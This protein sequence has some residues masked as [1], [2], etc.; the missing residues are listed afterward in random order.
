[1]NTR[2]GKSV[3]LTAVSIAVIY[4]ACIVLLYLFEGNIG[5]KL[6]YQAIA[7]G[8]FCVFLIYMV[9]IHAGELLQKPIAQLII[10]GFFLL[11]CLSVCFPNRYVESFALV[12]LIA[13]PIAVFFGFRY[14]LVTVAAVFI[15]F[16]FSCDYGF[17]D[18]QHVF[19]IT[20]ASAAASGKKGYRGD[21]VSAFIAF[22]IQAILVLLSRTFVIHDYHNILIELS[23]ILLN[24]VTISVV[25]RLSIL[26]ERVSEVPVRIQ[27]E[28]AV[29]EASIPQDDNSENN[30]FLPKYLTL[31]LELSYLTKDD[32]EVAAY[33]KDCAPRAFAR[34]EEIA[35]FARNMSY[36]FGANSDLVYAAARYHDIERFYKGDPGVERLLPEYLYQMI[37]RQNEK[38]APASL[39]EMIVLLSNH[40]LAIY[41]YIEKNKSVIST[42][43]VIENIFNLQ[44]RKGYIMT[45]GISMSLYHRMKQEFT[46]E[47]LIYLE[48][49]NIVR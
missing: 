24:S 39:E 37:R 6:L 41:H 29:S 30:G 8:A 18:F 45:A 32:C 35:E 15:I 1:M 42:D 26:H 33:M 38:Q 2:T 7:T 12:Y 36:K 43:K 49:K 11:V 34:A 16:S 21:V 20:V 31:P 3:A 23:I 28:I 9:L 40:V 17:T 5:G 47:F 48:N 10:C 4:A 14:A 22:L 27:S 44:L 19:Y 46:N 25:Y 13:V